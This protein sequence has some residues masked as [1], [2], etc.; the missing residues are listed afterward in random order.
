G[1]IIEVLAEHF[2]KL[3]KRNQ[4]KVILHELTHIPHKFNFIV[5]RKSSVKFDYGNP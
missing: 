3:D 4:D 5:N 2:D 1:Y